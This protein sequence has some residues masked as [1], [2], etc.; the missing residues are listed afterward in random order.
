MDS[1]LIGRNMFSK[2][3]KITK[4][5]TM[6]KRPCEEIPKS[7]DLQREAWSYTGY[8]LPSLNLNLVL[9]QMV[10]GGSKDGKKGEA[11]G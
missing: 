11:L 10:I 2:A 8:P 3:A 5:S 4:Q 7:I 6:I 9:V 1:L